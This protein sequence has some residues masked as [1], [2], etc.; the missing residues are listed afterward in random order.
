MRKTY[1]VYMLLCSD[2]SYYTGVTSNIEKRISEHE[3]GSFTSCYTYK[4]RPVKLVY[5]A[6]FDDVNEAIACEKQ[7]K[8]WTRKKKEA[9]IR[10]NWEQLKKFAACRN[11]SSHEN[12]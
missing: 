6:T 1:F 5:Y 2:N 4:R 9:L 7:L 8:K 3:Y 11:D 12:R 10:E